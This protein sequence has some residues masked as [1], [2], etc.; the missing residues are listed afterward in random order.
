MDEQYFH[1]KTGEAMPEGL[2][3]IE[4][5]KWLARSGGV[6]SIKQFYEQHPELRSKNP[7]RRF[8]K[9][10]A[11]AEGPDAEPG[12]TQIGGQKGGGGGRAGKG[13]AGNLNERETRGGLW[14]LV[15][16]MSHLAKS[17]AQFAEDEPC[18]QDLAKALHGFA[19]RFIALRVFL[20]VLGP[21]ASLKQVAE[22]V[23]RIREGR[24]QRAR[25]RQVA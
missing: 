21:L 2:N 8:G 6:Q 4:R 11:G 16:I 3:P 14:L 19:N 1:P 22:I 5:N 23:K 7:G 18:I 20:I 9:D 12:A 15:T 25:Q 24:E 10:K 13:W 17:D